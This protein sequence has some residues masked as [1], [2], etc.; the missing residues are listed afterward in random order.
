M[1]TVYRSF[2]V[3][4]FHMP[5]VSFEHQLFHHLKICH[6]VNLLLPVSYLHK[7][8]AQIGLLI[9]AAG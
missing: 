5:V 1:A 9:L 6:A 4:V 3:K 2:G 8:K 7:L